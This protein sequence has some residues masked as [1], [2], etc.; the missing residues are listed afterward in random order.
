MKNMNHLNKV[1]F[2]SLMTLPL[3]S[4]DAL[5]MSR[6]LPATA[7]EVQ[8]LG[9]RIGGIEVS[10]AGLNEGLAALQKGVASID[11]NTAQRP[12]EQIV[13]NAAV[14]GAVSS[15]ILSRM[16]D[17]M[18]HVRR[19]VANGLSYI[20]DQFSQHPWRSAGAGLAC[21][22][23]V[24]AGYGLYRAYRWL[25]PVQPTT[26][27]TTQA[28]AAASQEQSAVE[29]P[30][31]SRDPRI[32]AALVMRDLTR[33]AAN[34]YWNHKKITVPATIA[35]TLAAAA[36][37]RPSLAMGLASKAWNLPF[38]S[39][40][41]NGLGHVRSGLTRSWNWLRNHKGLSFGSLGATGATAVIGSGI[42]MHNSGN[43]VSA[44]SVNQ[45]AAIK[46]AVAQIVGDIHDKVLAARDFSQP[47]RAEQV[48]RRLPQEFPN[49]VQRLRPLAGRAW[50]Q[51]VIAEIQGNG[52][53]SLAQNYALFKAVID[54]V[55]NNSPTEEQ[56]QQIDRLRAAI[57]QS[58]LTILEALGY[59]T[60]Q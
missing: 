46:Q 34:W 37:I 53:A 12:V 13:A 49:V 33:S 22:A 51:A 30:A 57:D 39:I 3:T 31:Q 41:A 10:I 26:E 7:G 20:G 19:P 29:Q 5:A 38:G 44:P 18:P 25:R 54:T 2:L 59:N 32:S 52:D 47:E 4:S 1:L 28:T 14:H 45:D 43:N 8:E 24:P 50:V 16:W 48:R 40:V 6:I 9:G 17:K 23:T 60:Q 11:G 42:Y 35:A 15:N 55:E 27:T 21:A 58:T 36:L 56:T